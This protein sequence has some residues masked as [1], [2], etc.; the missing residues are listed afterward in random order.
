MY[1]SSTRPKHYL[2]ET[3]TCVCSSLPHPILYHGSY[4]QLFMLTRRVDVN[5][6]IASAI[7]SQIRRG[8]Q[9]R[10]LYHQWRI[11]H[12]D[13][14]KCNTNTLRA[15]ANKTY[16]T[17][18]NYISRCIVLNHLWFSSPESKNGWTPSS[19]PAFKLSHRAR[20]SWS[21]SV[22]VN[23]FMTNNK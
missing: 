10:W 22:K 6:L 12:H 19:F 7:P 2:H 3:V 11:T 14:A 20:W 23:K 1:R 4:A 13:I 18:P 21:V 8:L 9:N 15:S 5:V 16:E 17:W